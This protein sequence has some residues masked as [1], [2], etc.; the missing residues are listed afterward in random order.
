[1]WSQVEFTSYDESNAVSL[2]VPDGQGGY[3]IKD[4]SITH[5]QEYLTRILNQNHTYTLE[6]KMG[7]KS[8]QRS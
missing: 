8:A 2:S 5:T 1:M 7:D 4:V 3:L 6:L